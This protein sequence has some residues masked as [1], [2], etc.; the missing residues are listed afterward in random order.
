MIVRIGCARG[1]VEEFSYSD[2]QYTNE[3]PIAIYP[4]RRNS[5]IIAQQGVFTVHGALDQGIEEFLQKRLGGRLSDALSH[6]EVES[7]AV[8]RIRTQLAKLGITQLSL[9]QEL[10]NLAEHIKA[11]LGITP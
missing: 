6:I 4:I 9:F 7:N 5:R 1:H 3:H 8:Q 11:R 10:P 2:K